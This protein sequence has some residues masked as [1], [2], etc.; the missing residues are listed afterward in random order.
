MNLEDPNQA[1]PKTAAEQARFLN[2]K[3]AKVLRN[4]NQAVKVDLSGVFGLN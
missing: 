2:E 4:K 1:Q 3:A